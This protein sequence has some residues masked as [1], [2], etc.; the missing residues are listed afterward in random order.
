LCAQD[1]VCSSP[2]PKLEVCVASVCSTRSVACGADA[3]RLLAC[4]GEGLHGLP[5][6]QRGRPG[7]GGAAGGPGVADVQALI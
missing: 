5:L 4:A 3:R 6:P 7:E 2:C 1:Q